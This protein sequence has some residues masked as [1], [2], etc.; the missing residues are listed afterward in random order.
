MPDAPLQ[1]DLALFLPIILGHQ[2][3][4]ALSGR[5]DPDLRGVETDVSGELKAEGLVIDPDPKIE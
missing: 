5:A 1:L 3:V 2:Q 4:F